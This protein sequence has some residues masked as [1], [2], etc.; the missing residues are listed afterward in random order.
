MTLSVRFGPF[1]I[2]ILNWSEK[3]KTWN[4]ENTRNWMNTN[5]THSKGVG[6]ILEPV[7]RGRSRCLGFTFGEFSS[8]LVCLR[9]QFMVWFCQSHVATKLRSCSIIVASLA[10]CSWDTFISFAL[11]VAPVMSLMWASPRTLQ[12]KSHKYNEVR[13]DTKQTFLLLIHS[14]N[15]C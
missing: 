10:T 14:F 3:M 11:M 7:T 12:T 9:I 1:L 4:T 5:Q 6:A 15:Q 2:K 8:H 13:T